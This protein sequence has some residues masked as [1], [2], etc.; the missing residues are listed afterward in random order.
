MEAALRLLQEGA[1][2]FGF[3]EKDVS[4]VGDSQHHCSSPE[5]KKKQGF[6]QYFQEKPI[7]GP[8]SLPSKKTKSLEEC[9][10][11]KSKHSSAHSLANMTQLTAVLGQAYSSLGA[12]NGTFIIC[13]TVFISHTPV[14]DYSRDSSGKGLVEFIS[15]SISSSVGDCSYSTFS[16]SHVPEFSLVGTI[17]RKTINDGCSSLSWDSW[18]QSPALTGMASP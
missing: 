14:R 13:D 18:H 7:T 11:K 1:Q 3:C 16:T 9:R 2:H 12:Q 4:D 8:L 6:K 10:Q 17:Q 15:S 5:P